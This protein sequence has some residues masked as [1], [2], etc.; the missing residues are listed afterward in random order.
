MVWTFSKD[1]RG[2]I[3]KISYEMASTMKKKTRQT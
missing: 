1:G 2:K 3:A